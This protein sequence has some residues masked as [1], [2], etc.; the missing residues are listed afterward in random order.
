MPRR[1]ASWAVALLVALVSIAPAQAGWG[2]GSKGSREVDAVP[3]RPLTKAEKAHKRHF[4]AIGEG[5]EGTASDW[6]EY[7]VWVV[8]VIGVFAYM[9]NPNMRRNLHAVEGDTSTVLRDDDADDAAVDPRSDE[10]LF[11]DDR[12]KRE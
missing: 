8:G 6:T 2:K 3:E 10:P 9:L 7:I 12:P 4:F 1:K 11:V 5:F